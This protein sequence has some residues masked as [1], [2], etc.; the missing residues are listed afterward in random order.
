M[1]S[2]TNGE[3][4]HRCL[5]TGQTGPKLWC[6]NS[7]PKNVNKEKHFSVFVIENLNILSENSLQDQASKVKQKMSCP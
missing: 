7:V 4:Y 1:E 5:Q 3:H 2:T 6:T